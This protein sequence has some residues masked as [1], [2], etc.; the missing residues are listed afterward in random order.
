MKSMESAFATIGQSLRSLVYV[1]LA[2][3]LV[4]QAPMKLMWQN[5]M[6]LITFLPSLAVTYPS[7]VIVCVSTIE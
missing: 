3:A 1:N 7:N 6:Q 5:A 2:L 4:N